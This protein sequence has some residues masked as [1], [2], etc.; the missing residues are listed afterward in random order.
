MDADGDYKYKL[1]IQT[2][3]DGVNKEGKGNQQLELH[4]WMRALLKCNNIHKNF[5]EG[6]EN[7]E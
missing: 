4:R 1:F 6:E 5:A 7:Q 3:T 2:T